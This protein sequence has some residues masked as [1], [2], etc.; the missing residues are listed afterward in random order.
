MKKS[1]IYDVMYIII[2][3]A[4]KFYSLEN[5]FAHLLNRGCI[6]VINNFAIN[7]NKLYL[8]FML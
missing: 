8:L 4:G 7:E 5:L 6:I 3:G 2:T 1:Y